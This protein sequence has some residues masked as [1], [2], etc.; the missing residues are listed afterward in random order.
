MK[1]NQIGIIVGLTLAMVTLTSGKSQATES[2]LQN[3]ELATPPSGTSVLGECSNAGL[4]QPGDVLPLTY[5]PG[6]SSVY[7]KNDSTFDFTTFIYTILPGQDAVWDPTSTFNF[8]GTKSLSGDGK[9]LT[10]SNGVFASGATAL[11]SATTTGGSTPVQTAITFEGTPAKSVPEPSESA[12]LAV[13]GLG[14]LLIKKKLF[15]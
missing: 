7:A 9:V 8:F 10:F 11:F 1:I 15:S 13:L 4:C 12:A 5:N 2:I 3:A 6:S 14:G